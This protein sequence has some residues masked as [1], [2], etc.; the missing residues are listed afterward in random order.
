MQGKKPRVACFERLLTVYR[1]LRDVEEASIE[2]LLEEVQ[3]RTGE[4]ISES[5]LYE[6]LKY[7]QE[8]G[9]V[10]KSFEKVDGKKKTLYFLTPRVPEPSNKYESRKLH[11]HSIILLRDYT[12]KYYPPLLTII[13][14]VE[15]KR[16]ITSFMRDYPER[17]F[18]QHLRTGYP[19]VYRLYLNFKKADE[20]FRE[21]KAT[22]REKVIECIRKKGFEVVEELE[23]GRKISNRLL[24]IIEGHLLYGKPEDIELVT[25]RN[26]VLCKHGGIL[27]SKDTGLVEEVREMVGEIVKSETS[28]E[29]LKVWDEYRRA[30][31]SYGEKLEEIAISVVHGNRLKGVCDLCSR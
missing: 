7:L 29:L 31:S 15:Y 11:E 24:E 1:I 22:F 14:S 28:A 27:L 20:G 21:M 9:V 5:T 16:I 8:L 13:E 2:K 18:L 10:G 23:A 26:Y 25:E 4:E 6:V 19:D 12:T 17:Y 30:Y 3:R